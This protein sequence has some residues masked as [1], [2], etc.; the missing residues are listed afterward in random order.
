MKIIRK[1][2]RVGFAIDLMLLCIA[3]TVCSSQPSDS[4]DLSGIVQ[5]TPQEASKLTETSYDTDKTVDEH[6]AGHYKRANSHSVQELEKPYQRESK[7]KKFW[8]IAG[9]EFVQKKH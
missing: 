9:V 2:K 1:C 5:L 8:F 6:K 4:L 3:G 7:D